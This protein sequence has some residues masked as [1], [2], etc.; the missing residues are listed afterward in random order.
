MSTPPHSPSVQQPVSAAPLRGIPLVRAG[1]DLVSIIGDALVSNGITPAAGDI[2]CLAQKIVSKAED[3]LVDLRSV[4]PSAEAVQLARETDKD[5]RLVQ[6]IL[7]E[8]T[9]VVR[10]GMGSAARAPPA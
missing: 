3:R 2:V 10:N 8:S 6:L 1:D 5:P 9:T 7:D 4:T